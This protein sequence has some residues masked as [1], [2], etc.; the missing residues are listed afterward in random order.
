MANKIISSDDYSYCS[1]CRKQIK[2]CVCELGVDRSNRYQV[3][4]EKLPLI[5]KQIEKHREMFLLSKTL[6]FG[7][8]EEYSI[9]NHFI[10][11]TESG[12]KY[13]IHYRF[14]VGVEEV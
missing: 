1:A 3:L 4:K 6:D 11:S 13:R 12:Q 7:H 9:A 8:G 5:L 10:A 2:K 14:F